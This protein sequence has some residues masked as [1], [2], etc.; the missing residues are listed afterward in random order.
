M[1]KFENTVATVFAFG[2]LAG[3]WGFLFAIV[4]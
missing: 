1:R 2:L 4:Y 3:S